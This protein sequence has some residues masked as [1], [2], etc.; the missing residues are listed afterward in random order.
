MKKV[1]ASQKLKHTSS[2]LAALKVCIRLFILKSR[3]PLGLSQ[4]RAVYFSIKK[5]G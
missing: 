5:K 2:K 1:L 3:S 4:F